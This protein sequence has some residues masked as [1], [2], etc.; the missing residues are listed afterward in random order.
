MQ[1]LK[2]L[3]T[4]ILSLALSVAMVFTSFPITAF[5][6]EGD[7]P[8]QAPSNILT[9]TRTITAFDELGEGFKKPVI[10]DGYT[11]TRNVELN[12]AFEELKLPTELSVTVEKTTTT[13]TP[14]ASSEQTSSEPIS[15]VPTSSEPISSVPISSVPTSSEP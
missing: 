13:T 5:A 6:T 7:T 8:T 12:T 11:Y 15:S 4:R 9:I 3:R 2:P 1:N 14:P 10:F